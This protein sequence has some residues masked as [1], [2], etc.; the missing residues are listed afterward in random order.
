[1]I[2]TNSIV[3]YI[4]KNNNR[5]NVRWR[6]QA[7]KWFFEMFPGF[8]QHEQSFDSFYPKYEYVPFNDKGSNPDKTKIE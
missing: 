4:D 3:E 7:G 2:V 1:M 5:R 8:W 6:I